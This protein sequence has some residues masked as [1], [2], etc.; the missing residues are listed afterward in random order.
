M[1]IFEPVTL[2]WAG[3]DYVIP[4]DRVLMAIAKI[5]DVI[6]LSQL[7]NGLN[8]GAMPM[9]KLA[10]AF[11]TALR[12]AGAPVS[13]DEVYNALFKSGE[14]Q[15]QTMRAIHALQMLMI[16]PEHLRQKLSEEGLEPGKP[17]A[18]ATAQS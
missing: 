1:G 13:G 12:H 6:T 7:H 17:Q 14:M 16:P 2:K 11:A 10:I 15:Q 9:A 18:S 3:R 8:A 5:E 4:P